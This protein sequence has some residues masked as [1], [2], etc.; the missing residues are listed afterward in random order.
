MSSWVTTKRVARYGL[1]GF[2]RNGFVS[3]SAVLMMSVTLFVLTNVIISDAAMNETLRQLTEKVDVNVYF[4]TNASE[5]QVMNIKKALE[6]LPEVAIVTYTSRE[7]ALTEFR[8][9][10]KNDQLTL[11]ALDQLTD[12]PLGASL[13]VQAKQTSQYENVAKFLEAQQASQDG[14]AISKVNYHQNKTAIDRLSE[15]IDTSRKNGIAKE[16]VMALSSLLI[17]FNTIRL[18]IYTSRDEIGVMNLVGAGRWYVRGP[19]VIAGVLYGVISAIV[20]LVLL[21]P[22]L[23][24]YPVLVGL[25][26]SSEVLFGS[27]DSF[28]YYVDNF[29]LLFVVLTAVG[30][31]LGALSSYLAVRRYLRS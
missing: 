2:I 4:A 18:A 1:I 17:T 30:M 7:Q 28:A 27:F 12:N 19:F 10:H 15:I 8:E 20:V 11:Q 24:F 14:S 21:Y 9:R 16:I 22:V 31:G 3:F 13:A 23:L 26:A 5:E 29:A 6:A 25:D